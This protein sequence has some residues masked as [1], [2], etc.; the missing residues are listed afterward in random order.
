MLGGK[1]YSIHGMKWYGMNFHS[2][3]ADNGFQGIVVSLSPADLSPSAPYAPPPPSPTPCSQTLG[4]TRHDLGY[5]SHITLITQYPSRLSLSQH[6]PHTP[7]HSV[8]AVS[9]S[10][11]P[12]TM[13]ACPIF[14]T[15]RVM[16]RSFD[17]EI[18]VQWPRNHGFSPTLQ[19]WW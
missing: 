9:D 14:R 18:V 2:G 16:P 1:R 17:M 12:V 7:T 3:G 15:T 19:T 8:F 6:S 11:I 5:M 4:Q 13:P 10:Y